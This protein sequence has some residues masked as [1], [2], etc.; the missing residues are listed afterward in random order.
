MS[1]PKPVAATALVTGIVNAVE[2]AREV[3]PGAEPGT[4]L[5]PS[6]S[7]P[8]PYVVRL[9]AD[10]GGVPRPALGSAKAPQV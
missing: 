3:R 4:Y 5:V 8:E 1:R 2:L 7:Q 10:A 6:S 9:R